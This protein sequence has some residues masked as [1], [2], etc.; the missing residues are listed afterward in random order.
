VLYGDSA[1]LDESSITALA[2][3]ALAGPR[4]RVDDWSA[5]FPTH[6]GDVAEVLRRV[7]AG[8]FQGTTQDK[9][10]AFL[11]GIHHFSSKERQQADGRPHTKFTLSRMIGEILGKPT[12]H[13]EADPNPGAAGGAARPKDC[14]LDI[15]ALAAALGPL[16]Q[17]P[18]KE[19][20]AAVLTPL[21]G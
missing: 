14:E 2:K 3:D 10:G 4:T 17:T 7:V 13:L 9:P 1:D 5:R 18:L 16:P 6:T 8:G 12:D 20:L 11:S 19:G 15:T 21:V